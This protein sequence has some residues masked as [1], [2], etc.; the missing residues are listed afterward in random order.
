MVYDAV[1]RHQS[2]VLP[3]ESFRASMQG[4][5]AGDAGVQPL[6]PSVRSWLGGSERFPTLKETVAGLIDEAMARAKNNQRVAALML[7]I[8]PQALNQ[9]LKK[10]E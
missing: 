4:P 7:G 10:R 8:T 1:A 2:D 3:T 6:L 5:R 9:R